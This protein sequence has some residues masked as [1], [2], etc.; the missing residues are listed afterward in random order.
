MTLTVSVVLRLRGTDAEYIL[1][2]DVDKFENERTAK[3][4]ERAVDVAAAILI[5]QVRESFHPTPDEAFGWDVSA[6]PC[7]ASDFSGGRPGKKPQFGPED[8]RAVEKS[9]DRRST[10]RALGTPG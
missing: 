1:D 6:S 10:T 2:L 5:E 7:A 9:R 4:G 3:P 8:C